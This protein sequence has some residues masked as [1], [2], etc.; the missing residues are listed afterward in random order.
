MYIDYDQEA[1]QGR[2]FDAMINKAPDEPRNC[3]QAAQACASRPGLDSVAA[4]A[5][6][7]QSISC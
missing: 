3:V 4:A 5:P 6:A 1:S 2:R 7:A